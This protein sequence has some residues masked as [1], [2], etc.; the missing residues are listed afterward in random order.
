M[1][2]PTAYGPV[3]LGNDNAL[4]ARPVG[5]LDADSGVAAD[6]ATAGVDTLRGMITMAVAQLTAYLVARRIVFMAAILSAG[7]GCGIRANPRQVPDFGV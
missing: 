7:A 4:A 2:R 3:G 5:V 1:S 6:T